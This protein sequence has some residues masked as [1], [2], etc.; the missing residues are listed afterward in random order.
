MSTNDVESYL[1]HSHLTAADFTEFEQLVAARPDQRPALH[2]NWHPV[3]TSTHRDGAQWVS[4]SAVF[5]PCDTRAEPGEETYVRVYF[6]EDSRA[7]PDRPHR[8]VPVPALAAEL[9][10]HLP[11]WSVQPC[12]L[13]PGRDLVE[14]R[15]RLWGG[16]PAPWDS[17]SAPHTALLLAGPG[18][19]R[20]LAVRPRPGH[21]LVVRSA[22]PDDDPDSLLGGVKPPARIVFSA[23][24]TP[25][26]VAADVRD[27][28]APGYRQAAWQ[29]RTNSFAFA[30]EGLQQLS[31]AYIPGTGLPWSRRGE[32]GSFESEAGRNRAAW[33][34]I[35]T[36]T[37]QGPHLATGIRAFASVE[38]HLDPVTG[39][40]LRRLGESERALGRLRE[41]REGWQDA[42]DCILP[43]HPKAQQVRD[44]AVDLRNQEAWEAAAPLRD[45]PFPALAAHVA[46]R[47][48]LPVPDRGQQVKAAL[49]R[50]GHPRGDFAV[51]PAPPLPPVLGTPR[52]TR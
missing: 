5:K 29:A 30:A 11:G 2:T 39:P 32:A 20:F 40:A 17:V 22:L 8:P 12:P 38:D 18:G 50:T 45:G 36:L 6:D 48:A 23:D 26:T 49:A 35:T 34:Y 21:E 37:D 43:G 25:A 16:G 46:P 14:L 10:E 3:L 15:E 47:V 28:L 33:H 9:A 24:A 27:R 19:E 44:R 51:A 13:N 4:S 52:R 1:D 41:I 42:M 7:L 31:T